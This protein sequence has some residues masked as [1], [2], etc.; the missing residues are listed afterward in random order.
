[1]IKKGERFIRCRIE[2]LG[3]RAQ[4]HVYRRRNPRRVQSG[5]ESLNGYTL[6]H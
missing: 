4:R 2:I 5:G 6:F 3:E 1:L